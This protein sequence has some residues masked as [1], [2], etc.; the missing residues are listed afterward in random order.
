[1][2]GEMM[3]YGCVLVAFILGGYVLI[4][5]SIDA[6][7]KFKKGSKK[8]KIGWGVV[9]LIIIAFGIIIY[10][11]SKDKKEKNYTVPGYSG[12]V[13]SKSFQNGILVYT[14]DQYAIWFKNGEGKYFCING[15][16]KIVT[17]NIP[18]MPGDVNAYFKAIK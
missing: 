3:A 18:F 15:G 11:V 6:I 9:I 8:A 14:P 13:K 4:A 16:A 10:Q 2:S 17:D 12:E 5:I 7:K 1:M